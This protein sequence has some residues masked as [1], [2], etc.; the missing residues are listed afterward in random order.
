M[1]R[2]ERRRNWQ[3]LVRGN[4]EF[5]SF[6]KAM[7]GYWF[8]SSIVPCYVVSVFVKEPRTNAGC[9]LLNLLQIHAP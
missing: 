7:S 5:I 8:R 6:C 2:E 1:L 3:E 9:V 4:W